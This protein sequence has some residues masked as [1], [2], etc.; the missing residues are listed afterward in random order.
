MRKNKANLSTGDWGL[1][2]VIIPTVNYCQSIN[3]AL[4]SSIVAM[5]N[6]LESETF[7]GDIINAGLPIAVF[8]NRSIIQLKWC[9][10]VT[11]HGY[12]L[13][14]GRCGWGSQ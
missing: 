3:V 1:L 2:Y 5:K 7:F 10:P 11:G 14:L 4:W 9:F 12:G 8:D 6:P 13:R